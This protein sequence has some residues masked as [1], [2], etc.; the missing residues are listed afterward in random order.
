MRARLIYVADPMCSWCYGFGPEMSGLIDAVPAMDLEIVVGGLRAY[1]T[2]K[3]DG[4]L[5]ATLLS[6]WRR[7]EQASGLPFSDA[8]IARDGFVYDTEPACRAAVAVRLLAPD[9]APR[10]QLDV[11]HAIQ[12]AFYADGV[13]TTQGEALAT[14]TS[15]ALIKQGIPIDAA[16]FHAKWSD[17]ASIAATRNDFMRSRRWGIS[18]FPAVLIEYQNELALVASGYTKSATLL[19]R[20]QDLTAQKA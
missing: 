20:V 2:Q 15:A 11:F 6:H 5:K 7:V 8:A 10:M 18:G 16:A 9:L 4:R 1:N 14:I 13:D 12:R 17:E 3:L 19:E